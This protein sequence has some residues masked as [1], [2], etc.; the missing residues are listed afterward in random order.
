M[1]T[2]KPLRVLSGLAS[3][4]RSTGDQEEQP[5]TSRSDRHRNVGPSR[6]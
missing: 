3:F 5:S 2:Q 4:H 6:V 1:S